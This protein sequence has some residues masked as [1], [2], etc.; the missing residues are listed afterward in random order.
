MAATAAGLPGGKG[1]KIKSQGGESAGSAASTSRSL[2]K[3]FANRFVRSLV[4]MASVCSDITTLPAL[5]STGGLTALASLPTSSLPTLSGLQNDYSS[6]L[7]NQGGLSAGL[8]APLPQQLDL[9]MNLTH[10]EW[11]VNSWLPELSEAW[12]QS[13]LTAMPNVVSSAIP[14]MPASRVHTPMPAGNQPK[15]FTVEVINDSG[16]GRPVGSKQAFIDQGVPKAFLD[17]HFQPAAESLTFTTGLGETDSAQAI[18]TTSTLTGVDR[19]LFDL[20]GCP[21]ATAM[22]I[23]VEELKKPFIWIP[24]EK[25][26]HVVSRDKVRV[27]C[28]ERDK[29]RATRVHE[30]VPRFKEMFTLGQTHGVGSSG[31]P[32]AS[33]A[34]AASAVSDAPTHGVSPEGAIYEWPGGV[35]ADYD[36]EEMLP[37]PFDDDSESPAPPVGAPPAI[38]PSEP[39]PSTPPASS[40]VSIQPSSAGPAASDENSISPSPVDEPVSAVSDAPSPEAGDDAEVD[41]P[42]ALP[43]PDAPADVIAT[44]R[45]TKAALKAEVT[46]ARHLRAHYPHNP[47]CRICRQAHLKS[48]RTAHAEGARS[49]S[50]RAA[51][52]APLKELSTDDLILKKTSDAGAEKSGDGIAHAVQVIRD[53]FS[54]MSHGYSM[55]TRDQ[56]THY[57]GLKHIAGPDS[58][59]DPTV[60]VKSDRDEA[61]TNAVVEMGWNPEP[62][63]SHWPHNTVHE[64]FHQSLKSSVRANLLQAGM[65][66]DP[67]AWAECTIYSTIA[68][69]LSSTPPILPHEVGTPAEQLKLRQS[70]WECFHGGEAF[71]GPD[72]PFGRLCY[73]RDRD[74]SAVG[75]NSTAALFA[76]WDLSSGLRHLGACKVFAYAN[77]KGGGRG[78]YKTRLVDQREIYFPQRIVFPL[79]VAEAAALEG[80]GELVAKDFPAI[81][82]PWQEEAAEPI[83]DV[84]LPLADI[85]KLGRHEHITPG[86][87]ALHGPSMDC[88]KC[89]ENRGTHTDACRDRFDRLIYAAKELKKAGLSAVSDA[90]PAPSSSS[91]SPPATTGEGSSSAVLDAPATTTAT[92]EAI[93][94]DVAALINATDTM[95]S[96]LPVEMSLPTPHEGWMKLRKDLRKLPRLPG[97]HRVD[98]YVVVVSH[99]AVELHG[100]LRSTVGL[101][102]N[103]LRGL[104]Y[105]QDAHAYEH[106]AVVAEAV[107]M[108]GMPSLFI[109]VFKQFPVGPPHSSNLMSAVNHA[110]NL[111]SAV[112]DASEQSAGSAASG[113]EGNKSAVDDVSANPY[114]PCDTSYTQDENS[115][116]ASEK[117]SGLLKG[118][119][120]SKR[121]DLREGPHAACHVLDDIIDDAMNY[122]KESERQ[123]LV[124][125]CAASLSSCMS[126]KKESIE[127]VRKRASLPGYG[128][129][130]ECCCSENSSLGNVGQAYGIKVIRISE[131]VDFSDDHT[132]IQLVGQV[133]QNPG[134]D[135]HGSLPCTVWC[136]WQK[137]AVHR[138]G[139]S[140]AKRLAIR[141]KKS[142]ELVSRFRFLAEKVIE[143]GG[144]VSFEWPR[145]C[146]G[147]LQKELISMICDLGM[148]EVSFD[149]CSVGVKDKDDNPILK[150]WRIVTTCKD[151][152]VAFSDKRC[153]HPPGFKHS[154]AE[155]SKTAGTAFYPPEMCHIIL[156]SLYPDLICKNVPAMPCKTVERS[157]VVDAPTHILG[158]SAVPN[159][160]AHA[161]SPSS[162]HREH[163]FRFP[164]YLSA[165]KDEPIAILL[166]EDDVKRLSADSVAPLLE[167]IPALVTRLLSRAEM[168]SSEKALEAVRAEAAGLEEEHTWNLSTVIEKAELVAK[169]LKSGE[170][171]HLGELMSICSEKFAELA[172]ELRKLK[173]RIVYRG[174]ITK[175]QDGNLAVFQE[176]SA[177]PTSIQSAN[178]CLA[179]GLLKGHKTTQADA[180]RAYIQSLLGSKCK[181]WVALPRELWP[182]SWKEQ[183]FQKPMVLLVKSLYGHPE[184]GAH[185]ERHLEKAV[186]LCG[187]KPIP[188][189]PS[190]FWFLK[191]RCMMSVY[192][193]DLLLSGP[194]E[195]HDEIWQMLRDPKVGDIRLDD[196]TPLERF[197]GRH[198][199]VVSLPSGETALSWNME[200]FVGQTVQVYKDLTGVSKLKQASTPFLP[201]GA[202]TPLDDEERGELEG[203]ASKI[204]MKALW[205]AR[206][207]RPDILK[208]ICN[209]ASC[210][211]KW[212]RGCDRRLFRLIC[213]LDS[214]RPYRL[215]STVQDKTEDLY[216]QLFVDADFAGERELGDARSTSGGW[217]CLAGPNTHVPLCWV[218]KKQTSTSRSTT[219]AEI[220][221][222]AYS[223]FSEAIPTWDLWCLILDK[224]VPVRIMEDNQAT[225][226]V[227]E[228]G[229]SQKLRHV[230]RVH[231]V[232]IS[233]IKEVLMM[234]GMSIEYCPT[235]EQ[236][237]DI[238]TKALAP[239][240]W[241]NALELLGMTT[242]PPNVIR[243][244]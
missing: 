226:K 75:P 237:A 13:P 145:Y 5:A 242:I 201:D 116:T 127:G 142:L 46:S 84:R 58:S 73:M 61:I 50:Q 48:R 216:L 184:S 115:M 14:A 163:D 90:P 244:G 200:D 209:L 49:D 74:A 36:D 92:T 239:H 159:A 102:G 153:K 224:I 215:L 188:G 243:A 94:V 107:Q 16:A 123:S 217:L 54:G 199:D 229:F 139:P 213:Y 154:V 47:Y 17:R 241:P 60:V 218:A 219:E 220:I 99:M 174:D 45:L 179:Y 228:A 51:P 135:L 9:N 37:W 35:P 164:E 71:T 66:A 178:S 138:L 12:G 137:M 11:L 77:V 150:P 59:A 129:L 235:D 15:T 89:L 212:T 203:Q 122:F 134:I 105:E 208:P 10:D 25:P 206:L 101:Y 193:D 109:T 170:K 168:M 173:G 238:F 194:A 222:L 132:L 98:D 34:L 108:Y 111:M 211:Q 2:F 162:T 96:L 20:P 40:E 63:L 78:R 125:A 160:P 106:D 130:L 183:K 181:T 80:M 190:G 234:E 236:A 176:L 38:P 19:P 27:I 91:T 86:R 112:S 148:V 104:E 72:E 95:P 65:A 85:A 230:T 100:D 177:S 210:V 23:T 143:Y 26:Y 24:G 57:K 42:L 119:R 32:V 55:A 149:G 97:T 205:L 82:L 69:A 76:G 182:Q 29:I 225:I 141:R 197:L 4:A 191:Q 186:K 62:S 147:W 21:L 165:A 43:H 79:A 124:S 87:I 198:H 22:G 6:N 18:A 144:R 151:T 8:A 121:S 117:L 223:L 166:E 180:V 221:S 192:V 114:N 214:S 56:E 161:A 204:L 185:W 136:N 81:Q 67:A 64:R 88:P 196:P 240:K 83:G 93:D 128:K 231:G 44:R 53:S 175:D 172:P 207:A 156:N 146:A 28:K 133:K 152:A 126:S 30:Y 202:V 169:A 113:E 233:S 70:S 52:D 120:N 189:H 110:S 7:R 3:P 131:R 187:G 167:H 103:A 158:L 140:Y 232:D 195:H 41:I 227:A 171:I 33:T 118:S 157:A 1:E 31:L 155:G 68:L 39:P